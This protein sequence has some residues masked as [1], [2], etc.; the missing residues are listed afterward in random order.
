LRAD[1]ADVEADAKRGLRT[2]KRDFVENGASS[3]LCAVA[4]AVAM[5]RKAAGKV[6]NWPSGVQSAKQVT[7]GNEKG[8][9]TQ[10]P[11]GHALGDP[12]GVAVRLKRA[13]WERDRWA[14]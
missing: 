10:Q 1:G 9:K 4:A 5:V 14:L 2:R 7:C 3:D 6:V 8:G 11:D 13:H 12:D